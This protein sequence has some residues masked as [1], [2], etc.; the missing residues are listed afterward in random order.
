MLT[1]LVHHHFNTRHESNRFARALPAG[2]L[3][4]ITLAFVAI[5]DY[6]QAPAPLA[7]ILTM[8]SA[9]PATGGDTPTAL[10]VPQAS[11]AGI[12]GRADSDKV[13]HTIQERCTVYHS[14][15]LTSQ[16]FS[17]TPGG[18]MLDT[19]QQIQQLAPKIQTQAVAS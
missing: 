15:K 11:N 7:S 14:A 6:Q 4:M 17:A 16:L 10:A 12:A 5:P 2:A 8:A 3:G 19:L 13:Y 1:V 18:I 9:Q